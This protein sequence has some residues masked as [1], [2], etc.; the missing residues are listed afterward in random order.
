MLRIRMSVALT[1][2]GMKNR[3][4]QLGMEQLP[5]SVAASE[6][7]KRTARMPT[8]ILLTGKPLV[9]FQGNR[10]RT[11]HV[12]LREDARTGHQVEHPAFVIDSG[13]KQNIRRT[14]ERRVS[15]SGNTDDLN[16]KPAQHLDCPD[17]FGCRAAV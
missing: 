6:F 10:Q 13:M 11:Q 12:E 17:Q 7:S 9:S 8:C 16:S 2:G 15:L 5:T 1:R 4:F 14:G 3:F